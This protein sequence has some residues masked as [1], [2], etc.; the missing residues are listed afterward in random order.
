MGRANEEQPQTQRAHTCGRDAKLTIK[1]PS[2]RRVVHRRTRSFTAVKGLSRHI[3][4]RGAA[5]FHGPLDGCALLRGAVVPITGNSADRECFR[6][7]EAS[8]RRRAAA[9][10][11]WWREGRWGAA[12]YPGL[13]G[14]LFFRETHR[15]TSSVTFYK[16]TIHKRDDF[17]I[18]SMFFETFWRNHYRK[19]PQTDGFEISGYAEDENLWEIEVLLSIIF[20]NARLCIFLGFSAVWRAKKHRHKFKK[21][22]LVDSFGEIFLLREWILYMFSG[23][24]RREIHRCGTNIRK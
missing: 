11:G 17:K 8:V 18:V 1:F 24:K 6:D 21:R 3:L 19:Y 5:V 13:S 20:R 10:S 2:A 14:E 9:R 12:P 23:S 4:A 22:S 16:Q 15:R 7:R